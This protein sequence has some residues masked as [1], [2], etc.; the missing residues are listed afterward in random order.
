[1]TLDA[2]R[3]ERLLE[4]GRGLVAELDPELVLDRL[5]DTARALTG[6]R[7]A[8]LGILDERRRGLSQ[9]ITRGIDD[10]THREIGDLPRGRGILGVLIEQPHPL[11]L[12]DVGAHPRSYGFP[13]GHPPMSSFLG[14]PIVIRGQAWG[15]LYL[16]EKEGGPFH[17]ADEET[18]VVLA[19]WAAVAIENARLYHDAEQRRDDLERAL[20]RLEAT[21]TIARAVGGETDLGRVLELVVKRGRA[22]MAARSVLILLVEGDE[23]V[24]AAGAGHLARPAGV[25]LPLSGSTAGEVVRAA[26]ARR[27]N[28]ASALRIPSDV[29]GVADAHTALLVPLVYRGRPLGVLAAFDRTDGE[30]AFDG[31]DEQVLEA[32]AAQA[33]T[34]VA[35][36][37][38]VEAQRLRHSLQAADAER[39]RWAREL[40]DETLQGIAARRVLLA[41]ALKTGDPDRLRA[42]AEEIIADVDSDIESLR[43]IIAD[44]RPATL[45]QF[46]LEPALRSLAARTGASGL[47]VGA[48]VELGEAKRLADETETAVYR[49]V[50]EALN[51]VTKHA[52][53]TR[54]ELTVAV[55]G[56][57]L[58]MSVVDDGGGF[59]PS[60]AH[61]GFGLAGMRERAALAGG[62][63]VVRSDE[64]GTVVEATLPVAQ[65]SSSPR[66][67]A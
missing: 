3:L 47:E 26:T 62:T 57:E 51:N 24:V 30:V 23:L 40:H 11:R 39:R 61:A 5:L 29:L 67:S 6:A 35:T 58:H 32:F 37:K 38:T 46:G 53:A 4:A 63:L 52:G 41:T 28:D 17:E 8:A 33:A 7:Y 44:L 1:V 43:G 20:R 48:D 12:D 36:A 19:E 55:H 10:A 66:S 9:F 54:V 65:L 15:N 27:V 21:V 60:T 16:T 2:Q 18:A 42:A 31:D 34:A 14:V 13:P 45:D 59:D 56:D 25:R 22:L 50:Q 49:I 64:R